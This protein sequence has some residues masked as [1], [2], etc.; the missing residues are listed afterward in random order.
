MIWIPIDSHV[1]HN[2]S[3]SIMFSAPRYSVGINFRS[4]AI[5]VTR[6]IGDSICLPVANQ[7]SSSHTQKSSSMCDAIACLS[8]MIMSSI[9][10]YCLL[11]ESRYS[12]IGLD[13]MLSE[14]LS[15]VMSVNVGAG[16]WVKSGVKKSESGVVGSIS[17]SDGSGMSSNSDSIIGVAML[18]IGCGIC[19]IG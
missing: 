9:I 19:E 11:V 16:I 2:A 3:I 10:S 12:D 7:N 6:A 14:V 18:L 13:W 8:V 17:K 15:N 4:V 5:F 1:L